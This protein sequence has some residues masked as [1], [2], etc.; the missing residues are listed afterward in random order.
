M[1]PGD[2]F[3]YSTKNEVT[4]TETSPIEPEIGNSGEYIIELKDGF[5][6]RNLQFTHLAAEDWK[7]RTLVYQYWAPKFRD[8]FDMISKMT[9]VFVPYK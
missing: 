1:M 6:I 8:R 7:G 9:T 3:S 4:G 2:K 5:K